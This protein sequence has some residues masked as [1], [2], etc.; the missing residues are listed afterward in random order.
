MVETMII[1]DKN[2]FLLYDLANGRSWQVGDV[3]SEVSIAEDSSI[4]MVDNEKYRTNLCQALVTGGFK[5][6]EA[7]AEVY[8]LGFDVV[9]KNAVEGYICNVL[10]ELP[11]MPEPRYM[12]QAVI[13]KSKTGSWSL[14]V[15]GGKSSARTWH[16]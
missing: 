1:F 11:A 6:G 15:A 12:H 14:F 16:D 8:T 7:T 9:T 4:V 2:Q 3:E 10:S 13:A 5:L